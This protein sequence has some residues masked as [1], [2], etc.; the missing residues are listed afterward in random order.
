MERVI[1]RKM[2]TAYID[3]LT[4]AELELVSGGEFPPECITPPGYCQLEGGGMM[5]DPR[6]IDCA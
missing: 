2:S 3:E 6:R 5:Y 4:S 1:A